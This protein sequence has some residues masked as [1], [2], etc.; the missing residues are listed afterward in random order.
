ML[1]GCVVHYQGPDRVA[2]LAD[3]GLQEFPNWVER[4]GTPAP[5]QM[6]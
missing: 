5:N 1:M 3:S 6:D 4:G 2:Q